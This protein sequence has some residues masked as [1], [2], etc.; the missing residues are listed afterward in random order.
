[1]STTRAGTSIPN[2]LIN[3]LVLFLLSTA[4][5]GGANFIGV[6]ANSFLSSLAYSQEEI[7]EIESQ[8]ELSVNLL[9]SFLVP[10]AL[11]IIYAF[12]VLRGVAKL[13]RGETPT[14][15]ELRRAISFPLG[16]ALIG[17][18]GWPI[19][20]ATNFYRLAQSGELPPELIAADGGIV[21]VLSLFVFVFCYFSLEALMRAAYYPYLF[22]DRPA[23]IIS[24]ARRISLTKRLLLYFLAVTI[25]PLSVV[26][27]ILFR[28]AREETYA[29]LAWQ[30]GLF[31]LAM[32]ALGL[33]LTRIIAHSYQLPLQR[34]R[35]LADR[36]QRSDFGA[37]T[38]VI[39]NDELGA[40][41]HTMNTMA[42]GLAEREQMRE[43]FGRAVTPEVRDWYLAGNVDLGG[44]TVRATVLFFDVRD[45]T[46]ASER[47]TPGDVVGWINT[48]FGEI[49]EAVRNHG[50]IVNKFIGDAALAV[51]GV[52]IPNDSH[53]TRAIEAALDIRARIDRL[54]SSFAERGLPELRFGIGIHTGELLAGNI[55]APERIEYTVIGDTV[56]TASR[57]E[58]LSKE[59]GA[60]IIVTADTVDATTADS[61]RNGTDGF[62]LKGIGTADVRGRSRSVELYTV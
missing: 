55:G 32:I 41:A 36:V 33:L 35:E 10:L 61:I 49:A 7:R 51:F 2:P 60:T 8:F 15:R 52:P 20:Q 40:L 24:G 16:A 45:F 39:S 59:Y 38:E 22:R 12:P 26:S 62:G 42:H 21:L 14:E 44:E 31:V 4:V 17:M 29:T 47:M 13:R 46:S 5:V 23:A 56:N 48:V 53:S 50:G 3:P 19:G 9:V 18:V 30:A 1:M 6:L 11:E 25:F 28:L 57:V 54:N 58:G 34:M 37:R 27:T 43:T